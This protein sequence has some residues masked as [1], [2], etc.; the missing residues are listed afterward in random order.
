MKK[1]FP[2]HERSQKHIINLQNYV[3]QN[4]LDTGIIEP[5]LQ[6]PILP[7]IYK[8]KK[9]KR[10]KRKEMYE[11]LKREILNEFDDLEK[12][13]EDISPQKINKELKRVFTDI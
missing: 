11:R 4:I 12:N 7:T 5:D 3:P 8:P 1:N 2:R 13:F 6:E 9:E 10:N